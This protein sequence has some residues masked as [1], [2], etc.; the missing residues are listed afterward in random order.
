MESHHDCDLLFNSID[1]AFVFRKIYN[2][3]I[4]VFENNFLKCG[5]IIDHEKNGQDILTA[6]QLKFK[7]T[8]SYMT[9]VKVIVVAGIMIFTA[10]KIS[11]SEWDIQGFPFGRNKFIKRK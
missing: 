2:A 7:P 3:M 11:K 6:V 5:L 9:V 4:S 8:I 1:L 10:V